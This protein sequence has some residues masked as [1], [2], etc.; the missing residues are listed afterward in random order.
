MVSST[1]SGRHRPGA[2]RR[3]VGLP[4]GQQ[5]HRG[6]LGQVEVRQLQHQNQGLLGTKLQVT[7]A[8]A[9]MRRDVFGRRGV[10]AMRIL[11]DAGSA[12][13]SRS[14]WLAAR[15]GSGSRRRRRPM[16]RCAPP[17]P[18][19][20]RRQLSRQGSDH[21]H[22]R[23]RAAIPALRDILTA[24][25]EDRLYVRNSDKAVFIVTSAEATD[26]SFA[27]IDPVSRKDAG[28][29]KAEELTPDRYQQSS[30]TRVSAPR[31][32][33]LPW[34]I[35]TR[36]S[37]SG[38]G[39]TCS[40]H[41]TSRASRCCSSARSVGDGCGSQSR[42]QDGAGA[43]GARRHRPAR[44]GC[45]A[46]E[47]LAGRAKPEIRNRLA[48][49]T[50]K[51]ADGTLRGAGREGSC[52]CGRGGR[53]A[54]IT[55]LWWYSGV[56]TLFFGLSLGSILVLVAIGLAITFG[57]MGVINMAHGELMM[58]GAY[59]TYVVQLLM[60]QHIGISVLVAIPAA[61]LV[62]GTAG[63]LLESDDHPPSVRTPAR[64]AARDVRRQP[65]AAA[66]RADAVH[67]EQPRRVDAGL[68]ERHA[69]DQRRARH[70]AEPRLH[71]RLL[72]AGLRASCCSCCGE[73]GS[74][75]TSAR[76]RRIGRWRARWA[77]AASGW[78]R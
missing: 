12:V 15:A 31:S 52:G 50:E 66:A 51:A 36:E 32:R 6:G 44:R 23:V 69:A 74:V 10:R 75:S 9:H 37:V 34:R 59:T 47:T 48:L 20:E 5:G 24:F 42:N 62:A 73:R 76:W 39:Q 53:R 63:V 41:S 16:T 78:M 77:C 17:S 57:V 26:G 19:S 70:H 3:V 40:A 71:P 27:L 55:T 21:H 64:D 30:A 45:D 43:R 68:D 11:C 58:L 14:A 61:F 60:P 65:R 38:R 25:L 7:G 35:P 28:T 4:A 18:D 29:A 1:S 13:C 46:V 56:E 54:S 8:S 67:G 33:D 2:R 72:D 22:A 49:L